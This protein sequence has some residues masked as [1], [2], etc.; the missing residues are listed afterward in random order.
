MYE[1]N[2]NN[3]ADVA[4]REWKESLDS[5]LGDDYDDWVLWYECFLAGYRA[6]QSNQSSK[7]SGGGIGT[8]HRCHRNAKQCVCELPLRA[9]SPPA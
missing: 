8:C 9:E 2:E 5:D 6:A 4:F 7:Q 3:P 1:L